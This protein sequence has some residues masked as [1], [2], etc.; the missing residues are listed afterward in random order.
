[1]TVAAILKIENCVKGSKMIEYYQHF[2]VQ[3]IPVNG[4]GFG[5]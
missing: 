1:M 5:S 4:R 3:D 2:F